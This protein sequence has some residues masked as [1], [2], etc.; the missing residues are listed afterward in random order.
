MG[1]NRDPQLD[2]IQRKTL[3][4]SVPNEMFSSKPS[5]LSPERDAEEGDSP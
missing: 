4:H 2:N 3:E 1:I 5:P